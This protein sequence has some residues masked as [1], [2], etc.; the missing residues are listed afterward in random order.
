MKIQELIKKQ[1]AVWEEARERQVLDRESFWYG[2]YDINDRYAPSD[3]LVQGL[4]LYTNRESKYYKDANLLQRLG[5]CMEFILKF[6]LPDGLISLP[7][8]NIDSPPDTGFLIND[9]SICYFFIEQAGMPELAPLQ[10]QIKLFLQKT[11]PGMLT[12]GFHTANHRWVMACALGFLYRIFGDGR[13]KARAFAF[14]AEGFDVNDAGEWAERSNVIYNAV[15]DLYAFHIGETFGVEE[16]YG[17]VRRNLE[18]MRYMFHPEFYIATEYSTRQDRGTRAR[19]DS[20]YTIVFLLM[21]VMDRNPQYAFLAEKALEYAPTF[22]LLLLYAGVYGSRI[23]DTPE[24]KAVSD[25][26]TVLL[27]GTKRTDVPKKYSENGDA[28]LRHRN[29]KLSV[30]VMA[31]QPDFLFLQYGKARAFGIKLPIGWFGMG[32]IS[33]PGIER[34]DADTYRMYTPVRGKYWQVFD[35]DFAKRYNGNFIGMPNQEREDINRVETEAEVKITL[36]KNGL[37][38]DIRIDKLP[39]IFAQLVCML[40]LEGT[41]SGDTVRLEQGVIA[42]QSGRAVYEC[43][44]DCIE[45][46]GMGGGHRFPVLRGDTLN[47]CAQNL[48]VNAV[49]PSAWHIEF[50]C[51]E[52]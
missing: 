9:L 23:L 1:E 27:N 46:T 22:G 45:I 7:D 44:G 36:Q 5:L 12:G 35:A 8:C 31:G 28:V 16:A 29:G 10:G 47:P 40:D 19:M 33:F 50:R 34:I 25:C 3:L 2:T 26:Y 52:R 18:M 48:V 24:P 11:I 20:R 38:L 51:Y 39:M 37:D 49:S 43:D 13:L 32:G 4:P 42:L 17:A 21:S 41:V 30:T 15:S 14:L 6:Q